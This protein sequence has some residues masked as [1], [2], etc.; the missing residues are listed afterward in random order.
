MKYMMIVLGLLIVAGLSFGGWKMYAAQQWQ[1]NDITQPK[2]TFRHHPSMEVTKHSGAPQSG[3]ATLLISQGALPK[4]EFQIEVIYETGVALATS[5]SRQDPK[6][7]L[8]MNAGRVLPDKF[9][10]FE[11]ISQKSVTFGDKD[12]TEI[13]FRYDGGRGDKI[14]QRFLI[15][16]LDSNNAIYVSAQAK[17]SDFSKANKVY[18]DPIIQSFKFG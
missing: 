2:L 1:S 11:K 6:E 18:L 12:A 8:T 15:I 13:E 10:N 5:L 9:M 17:E 14:H 4:T 16:V 3:E 7:M